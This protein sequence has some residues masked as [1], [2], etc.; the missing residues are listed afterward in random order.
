MPYRLIVEPV[1]EDEYRRRLIAGEKM[2]KSQGVTMSKLSKIRCRYN[3]FITNVPNSDL[4]I[5][6]IRKVYYLRWQIELVFKT[7]KSY[8]EI[9]KVKRV[10]KERLE[11]QLIAGIIWILLNWRLFQAYNSY[12]KRK[13]PQLGVSVLKFFKKCRKYSET[14]KGV[15]LKPDK[16]GNW[17]L[18]TFFN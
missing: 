3:T 14:L 7:W 2:A 6:V 11:C 12:L 9:N 17:L 16:L 10:K 13:S 1:S 4:P 18:E 5:K 15:I 8:F